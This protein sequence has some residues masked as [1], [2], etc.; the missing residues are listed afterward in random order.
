M[1]GIATYAYADCTVLKRK[2]NTYFTNKGGLGYEGLGVG[3]PTH[4]L[5]P[6]MKG[7]SFRIICESYAMVSL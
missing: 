5:T 3:G 6:H 1:E 2:K 7:Y 4:T